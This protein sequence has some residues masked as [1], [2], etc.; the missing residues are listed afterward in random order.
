MVEPG[1]SSGSM[2]QVI[3]LKILSLRNLT[4]QN[5]HLETGLHPP[6]SS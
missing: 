2:A 6:T 5:F 3:K 4:T 1:M